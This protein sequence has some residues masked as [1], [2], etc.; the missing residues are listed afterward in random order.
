LPPA[1]NIGHPAGN[2]QEGAD[3]HE[4]AGVVPPPAEIN[5]GA[6]VQV[7]TSSPLQATSG[8]AQMSIRL[9]ASYLRRR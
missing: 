7:L 4:A 8:G 2:F 9:P 5:P 3:V 1:V 6:D